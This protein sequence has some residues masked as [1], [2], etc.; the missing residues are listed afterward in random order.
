M[1]SASLPRPSVVSPFPPPGLF[2]PYPCPEGYY[3]PNA[4]AVLACPTGHYCPVASAAP[5]DCGWGLCPGDRNI[6]P[7]FFFPIVIALVCDLAIL[8]CVWISRCRRKV[9]AS[10]CAWDGLPLACASCLTRDSSWVQGT[11]S[12]RRPP[13]AAVS[14]MK[15]L[16]Y[17]YTSTGAAETRDP[18]LALLRGMGRVWDQGRCRPPFLWALPIRLPR[19]IPPPLSPALTSPWSGCPHL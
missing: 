17:P 3:C 1:I 9:G 7:L 4:S 18:T 15:A 11:R 10:C 14:W 6:R 13:S 5:L 8:C 19:L 2:E 12:L 16:I